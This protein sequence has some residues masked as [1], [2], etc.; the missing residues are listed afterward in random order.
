MRWQ[1]CFRII[2]SRFPPI[3][4]FER[5][6]DAED[7]EALYWL[8][9]LTNP[10]LREE[11]GDIDLVPREDRVFGPGTSVI[12]AAFTH[13]NPDGSRFADST[14]GAFYAAASLDTAIAETRYHRE[15]FLRATREPPIEL[16]MRTYVSDIMASFHDIRGRRDQMPDIYDPVSYVA[17]QKFARGLKAAGSNGIVFDS[18]RDT[19]GQC[20]AVY[21]PRLVQN[22]RQS[23]HLRYVWNGER[24]SHVYT[25]TVLGDS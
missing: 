15:I 23:T 6:S 21:R 16:D 12:M 3:H 24:I 4:L 7:W 10:R 13:L 9:S 17:S 22:C 19:E 14:F 1:P 2:S 20:I 5:V 25:L 18:V 8:E 11:V